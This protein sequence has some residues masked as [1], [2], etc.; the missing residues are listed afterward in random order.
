MNFENSLG[1]QVSFSF[2]NSEM[3][4]III[5]LLVVF[6]LCGVGLVLVS[7]PLPQETVMLPF[8]TEQGLAGELQIVAPQYLRLGDAGQVMLQVA[9]SS[10]DQG[11][12][13]QNVKIKATLQT[14]TLEAN[15]SSAVTGVI[16]STGTAQFCWVITAHDLAAQRATMWGLHLSGTGPELILS[17]DLELKVHSFFGMSY[18]LLRWILGETMGLCLVLGVFTLLKGRLAANRGV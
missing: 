6:L 13:A 16:A 15:P 4:K 8:R 3:K 10:S 9:L 17:R 12:A 14:L 1:W 5:A 11:S 7:L 2:Y 18:R